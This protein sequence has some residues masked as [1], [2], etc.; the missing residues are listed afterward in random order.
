MYSLNLSSTLGKN[1]L[2]SRRILQ[3]LFVLVSSIFG[4]DFPPK[5]MLSVYLSLCQTRRDV[6]EIFQ[7]TVEALQSV[8]IRSVA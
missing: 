6:N 3:N 1:R 5:F 7:V 4:R 8:L 2:V